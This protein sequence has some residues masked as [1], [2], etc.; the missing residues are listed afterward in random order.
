MGVACA[1]PQANDRTTEGEMNDRTRL[2]PITVS[3]AAVERDTGLSKDTLR[4]WERRYG[5]PTPSRDGLDERA[6]TMDQVE[7]LRLIKRLLDAGHRPGRIVPL[8]YVELLGL[9]VGGE[10]PPA[11]APD[12]HPGL[13][14]LQA[15]I[16]L[17]R[18]H[19]ASGLRSA[20]T[21]ALSRAGVAGFV[22]RV[23]GPLNGAVGDAWIRG[24]MEIFEEH[25]YTEAVQVV[26]RQ[27]IASLPEASPDSAPRVLLSTFPGEP[28][29][30][31]LLMA[32]AMFSLE[33]C[34]CLSLGVQTPLWDT[35]LAAQACRSDILALSFTG[36]MNPNQV[37]DGL[38]E[39]RLKLPPRVQIWAGGSAPV[40]FRRRVDG[41]E[42]LASLEQVPDGVR[43]WRQTS[44]SGG[45]ASMRGWQPGRAA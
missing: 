7:K 21:R 12:S 24:Q 40:L 5:F 8:P 45:F 30:L 4:V 20:L 36:C 17:I 14:D 15:Y 6:Y 26:L 16:G 39:L 22:T 13:A 34:A 43:L 35:V 1:P 2:T 23:V 42:P 28:H 29:G 18:R 37:V 44:V 32:E 11:T 38:T 31:G 3:I 41:V 19:D 27:A 9:K 25:L 10:A 33:G